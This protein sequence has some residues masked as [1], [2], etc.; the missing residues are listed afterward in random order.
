MNG[1][2]GFE[3]EMHFGEALWTYTNWHHREKISGLGNIWHMAY[4]G[5][6]L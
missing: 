1:E 6:P 3:S 2:A 5:Y 4:I